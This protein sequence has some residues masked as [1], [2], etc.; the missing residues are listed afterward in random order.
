MTVLI[1]GGN[2]FLG[3]EL[4]RQAASAGRPPAATFRSRPGD[5]DGVTWHHLD[6][7]APLRL[8]EVLDTVTPAVVINATS[9][10]ADWAVCAPT[11]PS[12]VPR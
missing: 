1:L 11:R 9:G 8:E 7:R 10:G 2:G 12:P 5:H 4:V 3:S 6:V